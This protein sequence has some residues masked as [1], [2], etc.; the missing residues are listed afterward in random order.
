MTLLTIFAYILFAYGISIIFTQ[1][2]GPF[3]IFIRLRVLTE[4]ISDNF[5]MLFK[6]MLCFPTN[7]GLVFSIFNWFVLPKPISPFNIILCG[8]DFWWLAAIMDACFTG[9]VCHIIWNIDDYFD[10]NTPIFEDEYVDKDNL[11]DY[12]QD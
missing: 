5:G 8:T 4:S 2:T 12:G 1:S 11:E 7:V 9:G 3:N 6:C 10:K